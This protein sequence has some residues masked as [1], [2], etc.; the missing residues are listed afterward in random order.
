MALRPPNPTTVQQKGVEEQLSQTGLQQSAQATSKVPLMSGFALTGVKLA[1][2][3]NTVYHRLS[4]KPVG[5]FVTDSTVAAA[6]PF[7]KSWDE[8]ALVLTAAVDG[9]VD[10]WVY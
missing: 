6:A 10:I 8:K 2:G 1:A 4:R 9:V 7:R 5:W 3:D